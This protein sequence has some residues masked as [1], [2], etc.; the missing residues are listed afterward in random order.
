MPFRA[1]A[2]MSSYRPAASAWCATS[3]G[4]AASVAPPTVPASSAS[5]AASCSRRR[6]R[7]SIWPVRA[8]RTSACRKVNSSS[9]DSISRPRVTSSR[10]TSMSCCSLAPVTAASRSN[11]T[12]WPST[13]A[14]ST[15]RSRSGSRSSTCWRSTSVRLHG[16]GDSQSVSRSMSECARSN[17]SRKNGF[18]P[19]RR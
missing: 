2:I 1:A 7:P 15:I 11:G 6:C 8:S 3:A 17:S 4:S 16:S 9:V 14:A 10:S 13:A 5:R 12:R 18:P 19:V